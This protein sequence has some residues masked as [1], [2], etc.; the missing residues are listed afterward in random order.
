MPNEIFQLDINK[1]SMLIYLYILGQAETWT[2]GLRMIADALGM[3]VNTV[4]KYLKEL[5]DANMIIVESQDQQ[6]TR[7]RYIL[8]GT[9]TWTVSKQTR[10]IKTDTVSKQTRR[11]VKTDTL[12]VSKQTRI[13]DNNKNIILDK[14]KIK[15]DKIKY[16]N[17]DFEDQELGSKV[18]TNL[19]IPEDSYSDPE[20]SDF[21][22]PES[23]DFSC[24]EFNRLVQESYEMEQA[25]FEATK[26]SFAECLAMWKRDNKSNTGYSFDVS[27]L[28]N[29]FEKCR[30]NR[31][32]IAD[33]DKRAVEKGLSTKATKKIREW[34]ED[35]WLT[36]MI[37][38]KFTMEN[39]A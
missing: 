3:S 9:D 7:Q 22:C 8:T 28:P 6:G 27:A 12:S 26:L 35:S 33:M 24:P 2:P 13:Q 31:V 15:Y 1:S 16:D 21:S 34:F 32:P 11:R 17:L 20:D 19:P 36:E 23:F 5:Q 14:D 10:P 30:D 29:L 37:D 39:V 25:A 4:R 38:Y 18:S